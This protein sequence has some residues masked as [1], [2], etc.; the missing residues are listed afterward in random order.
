MSMIKHLG[1]L[2]SLFITILAVF[3]QYSIA[4]AQSTKNKVS[5]SQQWVIQVYMGDSKGNQRQEIR[6]KLN[7]ELSL[8]GLTKEWRVQLG[9]LIDDKADAPLCNRDCTLNFMKTVDYFGVIYVSPVHKTLGG[10]LNVELYRNS[11][12]WLGQETWKGGDL[13]LKFDQF[14]EQLPKTEPEIKLYQLHIESMRKLKLLEIDGKRLKIS[15]SGQVLFGYHIPLSPGDH[16][17]KFKVGS[18]SVSKEFTLKDSEP[19]YDIFV[20]EVASEIKQKKCRK[21]AIC[22]GQ[23]FLSSDLTSSPIYVDGELLGHTDQA[24][25]ALV[26]TSQGY[27]LVSL[28]HNNLT[29]MVGL[30]VEPSN[31]SRELAENPV[32][33]KDSG[34]SVKID[35]I[36]SGAVAT[37]DKRRFL[38]QISTSLGSHELKIKKKGCKNYSQ[39]LWVNETGYEGTV[40]MECT[41]N[42][43]K[44]AQ[45]IA[46]KLILCQPSQSQLFINGMSAKGNRVE[47]LFTSEDRISCEWRGNEVSRLLPALSSIELSNKLSLYFEPNT[48]DEELAANVTTGRLSKIGMWSSFI[49]S[50]LAA[51]TALYFAYDTN[52]LVQERNQR[53]NRWK[54]NYVLVSQVEPL[55]ASIANY[56]RLAKQ[57]NDSMWLF[58]TLSLSSALLGTALWYLDIPDLEISINQR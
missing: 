41:V 36:P 3:T 15:P 48:I 19:F 22:D 24:G 32:N 12:M 42:K 49:V 9:D 44:K 52:S 53:E 7:K 29:Y 14:F 39:T 54:T 57:S 23:V 21:G 18:V 56:D 26:T 46:K 50:S 40:E 38:G 8:L 2:S 27:H 28:E 34:Y 51:S 25:Q 37:F 58:T 55:R 33:L 11:G 43:E 5:R 35:G 4:N 13:S 6:S 1:M 30:N 17:V 31:L 16:K 20:R 10:G 45:K 47:R